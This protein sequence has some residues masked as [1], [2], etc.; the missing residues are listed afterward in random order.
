MPRGAFF[1][2]GLEMNFRASPIA[3]LL[4]L[5]SLRRV[6]A[7]APD[8]VPSKPV[9]PC[10]PRPTGRKSATQNRFARA[11]QIAERTRCC[12]IFAL[13][14]R[15]GHPALAVS[16]AEAGASVTHARQAIDVITKFAA[17]ADRRS[18]AP[19]APGADGTQV[20][21]KIRLA[22]RA[23]GGLLR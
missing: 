5:P 20:A 18:A 10:A 22:Y 8:P 14:I 16:L 23:A 19:K 13:G 11:A 7:Q 3:T 6:R 15:N 4:G 2:E 9:P 21:D 1:L 17:R 12:A